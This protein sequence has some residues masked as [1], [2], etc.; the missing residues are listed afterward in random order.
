MKRVIFNLVASSILLVLL[1][2]LPFVQKDLNH[3]LVSFAGGWCIGSYFGRSLC[4]FIVGD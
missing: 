1:F 2:V 3:L 4:E